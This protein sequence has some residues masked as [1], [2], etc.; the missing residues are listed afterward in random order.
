[1]GVTDR[2]EVTGEDLAGDEPRN[3][4][5]VNEQCCIDFV[6]D[7]ANEREVRVAGVGGV[8]GDDHQRS[9]LAGERP[10]RV[11]VEELGRWV[12]AVTALIEELARDVGAESVGEVA[13]RVEGH[14]DHPLVVRG[15]T[16][17]LPRVRREVVDVCDRR[18]RERRCLDA[19]REDRPE[20]DEVG[21]DP[22]MG[23]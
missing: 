21:V 10:Q 2:V 1:M 13:A 20:R 6:G 16:Q 23:L 11:V 19:L 7:L 12:D 17:C 15:T 4:R 14:A 5:H 9:E 3:V 18:V 8:A 22:G